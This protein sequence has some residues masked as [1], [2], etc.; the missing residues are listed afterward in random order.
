LIS[1]CTSAS[2]SPAP[3]STT[4]L[5]GATLVHERCTRCRPLS[6]VERFRY[7]AADWQS[8]VSLMISRGA[9]LTPEE[10][11][12]VVNYLAANFGK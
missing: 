1:S 12:L 5:D 4:T 6:R 11:T 9:Q 8:I 3:A 10:E 2:S 7:S